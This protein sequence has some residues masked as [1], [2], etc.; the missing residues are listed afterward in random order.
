MIRTRSRR[1]RASVVGAVVPL[2]LLGACGDDSDPSDDATD[3]TTGACRYVDD[4]TTPAKKVD[5]P[6]SEPDEDNPDSLTLATSAGNIQVS[7]E[8]E[9]APCAVNN[10][11]SLA[12]QGYF[13]D[14]ECH[15]LTTEGY[16]VLQC[17]DPTGTGSGGPGYSF[18]DEL[19][20]NDPRL[21]PCGDA[22]CTYNAGIVAMANA[23]PDTNGSQFFLVYGASQFPPDYT[24][25]GTMDAAGLKV[26]KDI[27]AGGATATNPARPGDGRP[28]QPVTITSVE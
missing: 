7:L 17:G 28:N 8:P 11:V 9:Q 12:A 23:G 26:L 24:V 25:L 20:D 1:V 13:D 10:L 16:F 27:A 21:Q 15:R 2:L 3:A 6:P 14:T 4:G 19:V 18:A 22:F 5:L